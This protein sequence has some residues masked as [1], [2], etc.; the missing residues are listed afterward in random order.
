[1][2]APPYMK[3]Y[4]A[5]YHQDTRHVGREE[6]GA[7]FLLLGEAWNRGGYLPDDD[8]V[9]A[10]WALATDDDW[11]RLKPVIM[12]FFKATSKGRWRHKRVCDELASYDAV[13]RKRK[14]AG[15][16]GGKASHGK[17]DEKRPAIATAFAKQKPTK[18]EPEP[19]P[20][21]SVASAKAEPTPIVLD[22][23]AEAWEL[24]VGVLVGQGGLSPEQARAF[25]GKLL[26]SYGLSA[27]DMLAPL[28]EALNNCTRNPKAFLTQSASR[29]ARRQPA[30]QPE[31][32]VGFV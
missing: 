10:R 25:F 22:P 18:P 30:G 20:V 12:A 7:Y 9:L 19:E 26:S 27:G 16:Q 8:A 13:S 24:A 32:R 11:R 23:K 1:L 31:R 17:G 14:A 5:D 28:G 6:H 2:S 29:R 15:K 21:I 4:W 3:L